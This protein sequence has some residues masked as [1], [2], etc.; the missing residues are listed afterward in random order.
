MRT[1]LAEFFAKC[2]YPA[3]AAQFLLAAYD[4]IADHAEASAVFA[5]LMADY[6]AAGVEFAYGAG[7]ETSR[8]AAELTGL[9][10]F[11]TDLLYAACLSRHLRELYAEAG[12]DEAAWINSMLDL[13]YKLME[14]YEVHGVW[15]SF[16]AGWFGGFFTLKRFAFG[17]LQLEM[18]RFN[19]EGGYTCE[20]VTVQKDDPVV[21]M[22]IP[23]AGPLY[24]EDC[25]ESF[26][27]AYRMYAPLFQNKKVPFYCYSWLLYEKHYEFL[28]ARSRIRDFMDFFD[29]VE[30]KESPAFGDCW[31]IFGR[32]YEGTLEGF[33]RNTGLQRAYAEWYESGHV[34]GCGRGIFLFDG[35]KIYR[36]EKK[37]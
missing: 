14:C 25:M 10:T 26:R 20:D 1:Y 15:G 6:D 12:L 22:H 29:I 19:V 24:V 13:R 17:R 11:T 32:K 31:R 7:L 5:Q 9:N 27:G 16:V 37:S 3:E 34:A 2:E 36:R 4:R 18:G 30:S 21:N 23:S 8:T 35:E 33:P 28:P